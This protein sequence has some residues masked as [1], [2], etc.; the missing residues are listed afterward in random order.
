VST[1]LLC[2]IPPQSVLLD[3]TTGIAN[4]RAAACCRI[5]LQE[6]ANDAAW[7]KLPVLGYSGS[8]FGQHT[9]YTESW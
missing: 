2:Q 5:T 6:W 8:N 4:I 9:T 3:S 1:E 7:L